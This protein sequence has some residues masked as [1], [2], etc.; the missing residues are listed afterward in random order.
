MLSRVAERV[1]WMARYLERA[2]NMARL[3]NVYS[4]LLFDMPRRTKV[5]WDSL[6]TITGTDEEFAEKEKAPDESAVVRFL[7]TEQNG[8]SV[9]SMLAGVRENARTTREIIPA[10]AF[11]L[12][13]ELY[14]F[15]KEHAAKGVAR[16]NRHELLQEI[17][18]RCQQ[19]TGLMAGTMS[20]NAAYS[21]I[22]IG[23]NLERAD[24]TTRIVDV[25]SRNLLE[26]EK[27]KKKTPD[28]AQ[29]ETYENIL[30]MSVLRSISA[31]QMYRQHVRDR[32]NG[33]D[34]VLFLMQ[35]P[36]FPRSVVHCLTQVNNC[37]DDLPRNEDAM[38]SVAKAL[39]HARDVK[40]TDLIHDGLF[41][42]I[43]ELQGEIG[44][45]HQQIAAT[46]FLKRE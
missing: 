3:L 40:I 42:F 5:G 28:E 23:R 22:R 46:W 9:R 12:I 34:V 2:E 11:E 37:I 41:L 1:Y 14:I 33:E 30:W 43:D 31:Y 7:L 35:N 32:V 16:G 17:V 26:A 18:E 21:F 39:R 4:N 19:I 24:M 36:D 6:I 20:H 10:E 27:G 45:V 44:N 38:I 8:V 29:V 25:G 15:G 13:N